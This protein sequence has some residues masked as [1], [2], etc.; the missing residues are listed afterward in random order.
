MTSTVLMLLCLSHVIS[1]VRRDVAEAL[2]VTY[3]AVIVE[4]NSG[5]M[6][7]ALNLD[8]MSA[9]AK[10]FNL[11]SPYYQGTYQAPPVV[12]NGQQFIPC[13]RYDTWI[14]ESTVGPY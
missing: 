2:E 9:A 7:L 5:R 14:W 12:V 6:F 8:L 3:V 10:S 1:T 13:R 11:S 4:N